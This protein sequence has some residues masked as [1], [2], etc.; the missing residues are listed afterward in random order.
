MSPKINANENNI[1]KGY[2]KYE[3]PFDEIYYVSIIS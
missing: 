1:R 2:E 3:K